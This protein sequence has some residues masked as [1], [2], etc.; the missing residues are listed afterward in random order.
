M[1][2]DVAKT[3]WLALQVGR[4]QV[5]PAA[6]VRKWYERYQHGYG[7]TSNRRAA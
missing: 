6:E 1:V 3:V 4:P 2:E 7:Q 5:L